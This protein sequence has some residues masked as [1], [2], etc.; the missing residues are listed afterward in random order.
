MKPF[1]KYGKYYD[2]I[3]K[4]KDYKAEC[5]F[6]EEVFQKFSPKPIK[7]I[8]DCG[9]GTGGHALPLA[10]KGYDVTG[11]DVSE[12]VVEIAGNKARRINANLDLYVMDMRDF[13]LNKTFDAC[14]SMFAVMSYL[15]VNEDISKALTNIRKHLERDSLFLFDCW[16][17][18][19]VLR[20]LPSVTVKTVEEGYRR[21]IRIAQ[22]DLD[23][24][25]HL[26]KVNYQLVVTENNMVV[27]EIEEIHMVRFLFPQEISHYLSDAGF[28]LKR[29]CPFLDL[30]GRV[31][32]SV[33]NMAIIAMAV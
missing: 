14:I 9:L 5:V 21:V 26:C 25:R 2:L 7:T 11:I 3:Y 24:F 10:R 1:E 16:N 12:V 22:P 32:E 8:L 27:D 31:D 18:L 29:I 6:I 17:G 13:M 30:N 28:E 4:D 15:T 20:I 23:A 33:W 19:A